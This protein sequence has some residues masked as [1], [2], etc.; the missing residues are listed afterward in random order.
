MQLKNIR[1]MLPLLPLFISN[2]SS[3]NNDAE[4]IK[5]MEPIVISATRSNTEL[6][7]SPQVITVITKEQIEQQ[8]A[9]STD[10]SQLL[11][12]L[13]P[14]FAP[15][16]QKLSGS[17][18]TF[19]G[20]TPLIM[21]DGVPQSNPL[22]D[23][24]RS[25]HTIDLAIV[26]RIEVIHGSNAIHG[27]GATGGII[28]YITRRPENGSFNQ[29]VSVQATTPT[30]ELDSETLSYKV[31]YR[32]DGN[33]NDFDYLAS[34]SFE[35]QG[36]FLDGDGNAIGVDNTQG[37]LM[38]SQTY[39]LF[40]KLGYW[41]DDDQKVE[42]QINQYVA[43]GNLNYVSVEGDREKGIATTSEK[44]TPVGLAPH[45]RVLTMNGNYQN[46]DLYGMKLTL[47]VYSQ[48]F[49]GLF[50][51][52]D[53]KTFQDESIAP[54]GTLYDQSKVESSKL[55]AKVTLIKD[56]LL[57]DKLKLTTGFDVLQDTTEQSL[58]LT[59]RSWV[60]ES[61]FI[62]YAPF[63]QVQV[64][65]LDNLELH[66]GIR[67]EVA[68]L[69]VD[70][71]QTIASKNS[72]TVNG[73]SPDFE[74]SLVNFGVVYHPIESVRFFASYSEGFTMADV[75]RVLRG[76]DEADQDIDLFLDLEPIVTENREVGIRFNKQAI[77]FEFSYYQSLSDLGSRLEEV[78]G[79][80]VMK[81]EKTEITGYEAVAGYQ[82]N[83]QHKLKMAYS[84][85]NGKFDSDKNGSLDAKL[86]GRN[87]AP[88]RL[89]S[90]WTSHW[91]EKVSALLQASYAFDRS[92]DDPEKEF[93]GYT[94]V[95]ASVGY[96]LSKGKV[97]LS[98]ANLLDE[99]YITYY[100]QS[101]VVND[102]RYFKGR[103]RTMTLGYALDF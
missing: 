78:D 84:H 32:V 8:L 9:I 31:N 65:V 35:D 103:G 94:L 64:S 95:D 97:S 30:S 45:N 88:N 93:S 40:A 86:D 11:S 91:N 26:E 46:D 100:S 43:E 6:L 80:F 5:E 37:D 36:L 66:T 92:F 18:E 33:T 57:D 27:L 73:G 83:E 58:A 29:H 21:I 79:N 7:D 42:F 23:T 89:I 99:D 55:G 74:E 44:G 87:I 20:R 56:D 96:N 70:T 19:R 77:D 48:Q 4:S 98:V 61:D 75:G 68:K 50:G 101:A 76:I 34:A 102:D 81:R 47:L 39:D 85:I 72:V 17:G 41:I 52:T 14:A 28:N 51:A 82:L 2:Q 71:Y 12:S 16:R 63:I 62:N 60:P 69:D 53:S 1:Y 10:S 38:D 25:A 59:N 49:E 3:A 13:L 22:R 54:E 67:Y 90:S 15:S 24:G